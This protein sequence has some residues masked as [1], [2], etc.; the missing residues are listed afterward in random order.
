M[1]SKFL[2]GVGVVGLAL[3]GGFVWMSAPQKG[4]PATPV[5]SAMHSGTDT[6]AGLAADAIIVPEFSAI[7]KQGEANFNE[8]C[9]A[10]HGINVAGTENGP[11]LIHTLYRVGHHPDGAFVSAARSGVIA[12]HWQFG[13]MPPVEGITDE[14]LGPIL[15][16]LREIQRANGIN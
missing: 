4:G 3:A 16:Y 5:T 14:T 13:N 6:D 12:H 9:A 8:N 15:V 11:T 2:I 10:C 7:A 1:A